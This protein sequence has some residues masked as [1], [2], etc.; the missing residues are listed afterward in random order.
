MIRFF[1][2]DRYLIIFMNII[3]F[4]TRIIHVNEKDLKKFFSMTIIANEKSCRR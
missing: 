3:A 4:F 2:D 1:L